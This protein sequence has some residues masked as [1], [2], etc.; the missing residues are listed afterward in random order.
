[1]AHRQHAPAS[2]DEYV[3]GLSSDVTAPD[4]S[5]I[6]GDVGLD[7][8]TDAGLRWEVMAPI[9]GHAPT[10]TELA[11][12]DAVL[13]FGHWGYSRDVAA[14]TP[15][16]KHVARFGAGFDGI[17]LAG[18]A[19][20]GVVVTNTPDGV[21]RPLAL[22][23]M[24]LL[25]ALSHRLLDNQRAVAEGRWRDRG[26][27]RGLGLAGR[28]VGIIG[29]GS[30]GADLAE[31]IAPLGVRIIT[32]DRPSVRARQQAGELAGVELLSLDELAARSDYVILTASLTPSSHHMVD[33]DFLARMPSTSYVINVGRGPLIDQV[34]LTE[35]LRTGSIA[36]AGLDVLESEPPTADE[37]LLAMDSVIVTPH[38]LCW[39]ADFVQDVAGSVMEALIDVANGRPPSHPLN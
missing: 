1:M 20:E 33:A 38:A 29:F 3:V 12:Y 13:S 34:A 36:G 14:A 2:G 18:L 30:V 10:A 11:P 39:T 25:L 28:T 15:R 16:L 37:P 26:S 9:A 7:R 4:G 17:D 27:Y 5:T 6:F 24:T 19:D 32:V 22:A 35:A 21:R 31:L 23:A 8:L